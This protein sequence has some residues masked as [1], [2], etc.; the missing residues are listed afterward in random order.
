MREFKGKVLAVTVWAVATALIH[1]YPIVEYIK[2]TVLSGMHILTV[3]SLGFLLYP[4]TS[5][6]PKR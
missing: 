6:V 3:L 1:I 4:A 5:E 2:T